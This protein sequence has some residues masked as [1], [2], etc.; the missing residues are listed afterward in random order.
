M[1]HRASTSFAVGSVYIGKT[2][3]AKRGTELF[4][5]TDIAQSEKERASDEVGNSD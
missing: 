4:L 5:K 3:Y 2:H 1:T